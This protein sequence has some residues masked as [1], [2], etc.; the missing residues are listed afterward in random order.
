MS[1]RQSILRLWHKAGVSERLKQR[2]F[3]VIETLL[4]NPFDSPAEPIRVLDAGC[5][6]G[7]DFS[8]FV[9]VSDNIELH[10]VDVD[11]VGEGLRQFTGNPNI[12][13]QVADI[14]EL[15]FEDDFFDYAVSIGVL[16]HIQPIESLCRAVSELRRVSKRFCH[17]MPSISTV[18]EPHM[19]SLR[20]Q[21]RDH[22]RKRRC[23]ALNYFSDEAWL[24]FSGFHGCK[25]LTKTYMPG[26]R[27]VYIYDA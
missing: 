6:T 11:D 7:K 5:A 14:C 4:G 16:E 24:Q 25:I 26:I 8:R 27:N 21:L 15:P 20:W 10:G 2:R 13:F 12:R 17:L 1:A 23:T 9:P 19:M 18:V 22:N 3:R